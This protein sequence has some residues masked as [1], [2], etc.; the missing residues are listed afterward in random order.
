MNADETS[1]RQHLREEG[2]QIHRRET[3]RQIILPYM[4]GVGLLV[5]IFL[6]MALPT[7]PVWRLRASAVGDF[8]YTLLCLLPLCLC[9]FGAY[10]GV[11]VGIWGMN[12]LHASTERPLVRV[13][14]LVAGLATRV[15]NLSEMINT[16]TLDWRAKLEQ[17]LTF[18]SVFEELD[19]STDQ[20]TDEQGDESA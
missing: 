4:L 10:A 17:V 3:R 20:P 12:K 16:R 14:N 8:L 9:G 7:D 5:V 2:R 1:K 15:D 6:I 13:E 19:R 11:M 18:L